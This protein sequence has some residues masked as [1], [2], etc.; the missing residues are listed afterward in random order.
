MLH[1][2]R[3]LREIHHLLWS[4]SSLAGNVVDAGWN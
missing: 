3:F 1:S 4:A 2:E